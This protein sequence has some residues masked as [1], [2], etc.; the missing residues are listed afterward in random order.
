MN[1]SD[2]FIDRST[3]SLTSGAGDEANGDGN[4]Q[5]SKTR[6]FIISGSLGADLSHS[7]ISLI[8]LDQVHAIYVHCVRLMILLEGELGDLVRAHPLLEYWCCTTAGVDLRD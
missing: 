6:F 7:F 2:W 4:Q 1:D 5:N 8:S 3:D